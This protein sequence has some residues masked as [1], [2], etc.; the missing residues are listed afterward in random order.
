MLEG[1]AIS[2][3]LCI[4]PPR[5]QS[6]VVEGNVKSI[7]TED[8]LAQSLYSSKT[9]QRFG[10]H[11]VHSDSRNSADTYMEKYRDDTEI[12][13]I[14]DEQGDDV[15]GEVNLEDK[16]A[17]IDEDQ[18]GSGPGETHESRPPPEKVIIDEDQA[19]R[20]PRE[21]SVALD[22]PDPEPTHD[23]FM[24]DLYPKVQESLKFS[25]DEHVI[26]EEPLSSS[27]TLSSLKNR[28]DAYTIGEHF[29]NDKAIEVEPEKLNVESEVVSM[30]TVLIYQASSSVPPMSTPVIDLSPPKP[31]PSTTQL[32][33]RVTTLEQEFAAFEQMSKT[34]DNT[35]QNLGSRV[36]N[37]ELR[38]LPHKIDETVLETVKEV[39]QVAL[40]DPLRDHFRGL[41]EADIKEM[42]HQRMFETGSYKPLP[43]HVALYEF[44]EASMERAQ[45][46][47]FFAEWDKSCKRRHDDQDP[48]PPPPDSDLSKKKRH[49]SGP[50]GSSQPLAP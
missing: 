29:I 2:E 40:Q 24:A 35:T 44:L 22:G 41:P 1:V 25:A 47:E 4:V 6:L 9:H 28:D 20:D 26:L 42:L 38:D 13:H 10:R 45:R 7:V 31:A 46:D 8:K 16:T 21:S 48:P 23:E 19:G 36:F 11:P 43:E 32:A 17:E 33:A 27:G 37:L 12:L 14:G 30:A 34:L 49:D 50:L 5:A 39:V 3:N 18:A 15:T